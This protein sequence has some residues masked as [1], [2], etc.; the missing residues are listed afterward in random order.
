MPEADFQSVKAC[1][2]KHVRLT[3]C[4][5]KADRKEAVESIYMIQNSVCATDRLDIDIYI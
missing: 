1:I 5:L 4:M 3:L 2:Y